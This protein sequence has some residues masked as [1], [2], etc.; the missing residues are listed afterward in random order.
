MSGDAPV[1]GLLHSTIRA[2][3][4]S[5]ELVLPGATEAPPLEVVHL[6]TPLDGLVV[7]SLHTAGRWP[8]SVAIPA[9]RISDGVQT[10]VVRRIDTGAR[11]GHFTLIAGEPLEDDL[12]AEIDLLRAELDLLKKAFRRHC[13]ES[14][15]P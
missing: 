14:R 5:A 12:R 15:S 7:G 8:L 9:E 2:G 11:L 3:V 4:W 10:F 1:A 6:G 13:A